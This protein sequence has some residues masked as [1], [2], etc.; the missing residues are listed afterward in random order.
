MNLGGFGAN[1]ADRKGI[2]MNNSLCRGPNHPPPTSITLFLRHPSSLY[3]PLTLIISYSLSPVM[4]ISPFVLVSTLFVYV[5]PFFSCPSVH[6]FS[7]EC[8]TRQTNP[9][10]RVRGKRGACILLFFPPSF[11]SCILSPYTSSQL[12]VVNI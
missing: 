7:A 9:G 8:F 12:E 11:L 3:Y 10:G 1:C 6:L 5:S 2:F 4:P